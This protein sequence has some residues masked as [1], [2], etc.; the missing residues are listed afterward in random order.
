MNMTNGKGGMFVD[1]GME[2]FMVLLQSIHVCIVVLVVGKVYNSKSMG[3]FSIHVT[4]GTIGID[5]TFSI[6]SI[7]L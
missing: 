7:H 6:T 1:L 4:H 3:H 2:G 5:N